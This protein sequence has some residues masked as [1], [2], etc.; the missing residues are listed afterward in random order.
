MRFETATGFTQ[1]ST[2]DGAIFRARRR[3]AVAEYWMPFVADIKGSQAV[4]NGSE[5]TGMEFQFQLPRRFRSSDGGRSWSRKYLRGNGQRMGA[6]TGKAKGAR[7]VE[8]WDQSSADRDRY[9]LRFHREL[10]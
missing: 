3:L 9:G 6:F 4:V 8:A 5:E 1:I 10:D 7:L 2:D